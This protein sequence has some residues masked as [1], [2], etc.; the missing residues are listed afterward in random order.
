MDERLLF[1]KVLSDGKP[2]LAP[3]EERADE[4][5]ATVKA[6]AELLLDP[7]RRARSPEFHRLA[8]SVMKITQENDPENRFP[9]L[10]TFRRWLKKHTGLTRRSVDPI[11]GEIEREYLSMS[12]AA[13]DEDAFRRWFARACWIIGND[14]LGVPP[15]TVIDEAMALQSA[16]DIAA[17]KKKG[18]TL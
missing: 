16:A 13:M 3:A 7:P 11:T 10:E 18:M 8:F 12:F 17:L 1:T 9:D 2:Y 15:K 14:V 4:W 6:K 5:I